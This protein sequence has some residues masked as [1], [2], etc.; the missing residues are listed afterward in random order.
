MKSQVIKMIVVHGIM[1]ITATVVEILRK[2]FKS[3]FFI[4]ELAELRDGSVCLPREPCAACTHHYAL[5]HTVDV[6]L[7]YRLVEQ[8]ELHHKLTLYVKLNFTEVL[9]SVMMQNKVKFSATVH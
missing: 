3:D 6:V 4:A 1:N 8:V 7:F 2:R 5:L 9:F